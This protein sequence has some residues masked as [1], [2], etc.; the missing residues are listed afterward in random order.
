MK[1]S[2]FEAD[3]KDKYPNVLDTDHG[4]VSIKL[5]RY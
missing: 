5:I 2:A 4:Y 3:L 1:K